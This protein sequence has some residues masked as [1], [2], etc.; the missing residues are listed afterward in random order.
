MRKDDSDHRVM[1]VHN[2]ERRLWLGF[3]NGGCASVGSSGGDSSS[4][5][6]SRWRALSMSPSIAMQLGPEPRLASEA[7]SKGRRLRSS[8][9][10]VQTTRTATVWLARPTS[11][12]AGECRRRRRVGPSSCS[13]P[14]AGSQRP[15]Q[16][17]AQ[18][19]A[20]EQRRDVRGLCQ[21]R[22]LNCRRH[23]FSTPPETRP[24]RQACER[25]QRV[26]SLEAHIAL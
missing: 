17:H 18:R 12:A 24:R 19:R 4:S 13:R 3:M 9:R 11:Q 14:C 22:L 26:R 7:S 6:S 25:A 5:S 21:G 8:A 23:E 16:T 1:V 10:R 15:W 2:G 20:G